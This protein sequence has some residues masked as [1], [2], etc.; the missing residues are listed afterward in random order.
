MKIRLSEIL[1]E[2]EFFKFNRK[3]GELNESL[4][5]LIQAEPY[6]TEFNVRPL[7]NGTF[8]LAGQFRSQLA[9]D[10]SRCGDDF[11]Y[12][13]DQKF[14]ELLMPK[15][16]TQRTD[17]FA[18]PNHFSDLSHSGPE[19]YE[20][21]GDIF[22][23]G[24]YFHELVALS[25]PLTPAPALDHNSNCSLC[26]KT[27]AEAIKYEDKGWEKPETPFAALKGLKVD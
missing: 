1:D 11:K 23:A 6:E 4:R 15:L 21:N 2:G 18:K 8:E 13:V 19:V 7:G 9:E 20:V 26:K 17:H 10:C 16:S 27:C 5:D 25:Q 14:T 22:D 3:T 24:E 12:V